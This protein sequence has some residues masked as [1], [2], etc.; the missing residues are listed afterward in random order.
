M[1]NSVK[2]NKVSEHIIDQIRQAI[3]EGK[4]KP[5]DRLPPEMKLIENFRVS[6]A[7]L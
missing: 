1:F 3:L 5:G 4:L 2:P 7:A 6:K